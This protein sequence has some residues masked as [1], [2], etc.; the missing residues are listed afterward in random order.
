MRGDV[1]RDLGSSA[2]TG[3]RDQGVEG[4]WV[5]EKWLSAIVP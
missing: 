4:M 1:I 2:G 3:Q 5:Q